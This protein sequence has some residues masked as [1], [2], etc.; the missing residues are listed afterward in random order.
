MVWYPQDRAGSYLLL[1]NHPT[2]LLLLVL[3]PNG[4][5]FC[6]P[7]P[8]YHQLMGVE[9]VPT[10]AH[11]KAELLRPARTGFSTRAPRFFTPPVPW[12]KRGS[13]DNHFVSLNRGH[14]HRRSISSV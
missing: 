2:T 13:G 1:R 11:L 12:E 10:L 7:R 6:R 5:P 14:Y 8:T 3:L 9:H 4:L